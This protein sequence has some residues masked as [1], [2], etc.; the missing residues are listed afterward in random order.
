M[1]LEYPVISLLYPCDI[2]GVCQPYSNHISRIYEAAEYSAIQFGKRTFK[3]Y[4]SYIA[5]AFLNSKTQIL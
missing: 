5:I 1:G 2:L 4:F 3:D